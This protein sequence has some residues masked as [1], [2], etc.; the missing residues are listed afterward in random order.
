VEPGVLVA[1]R[2]RVLSLVGRGAMGAVW[3]AHDERLDRQVAVK[4]LVLDSSKKALADEAK[5]RAIR[6]GRNAGRL[7]HPNAIIVYDVVEHEGSPCLVMEYLRAESLADRGVRSVREAA[8]LGAQLASALAAAHDAGIVHRDIK[9]DNVLVT[10][11][12]TAKITD[13]GISRA[14]GDSRVTA[15]G[16]LAGTPAY[17][18][19]EVARGGDA[20]F[21]SDVFSLGATLYAV[22]EGEPPFGIDVNAIALLHKVARGVVRPPTATGD[23]TDVLLWLLQPDPASRPSMRIAHEALS[24]VAGGRRGPAPPPRVPTMTLPRRRGPSRRTVVAGVGAVVLVAGGI[25]AGV[26][27][28]NQDPAGEDPPATTASSTPAPAPAPAGDPTCTA[29]YRVDGSWPDGYQAKVTVRNTGDEPLTG[30]QLTWTMPDGHEI[31]DLWNGELTT[32]GTAVTVTNAEY[33]VTIAPGAAVEVG[34]NVGSDDTERP[35]P[36]VACQ[37]R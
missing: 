22:L 25:V 4:Q 8:A 37:E 1:G 2:Y 10:G 23:L 20:D 12:G 34:L 35:V 17:L 28:S 7:R 33:N 24:A 16:I 6:E 31:R 5:A 3:L 21:R 13:F 18:A 9:P 29:N 14:P 11:D 19:P 30:W 26:L 36:E 32:D 15:T 27:L